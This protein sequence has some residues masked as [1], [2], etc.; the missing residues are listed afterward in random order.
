MY[1]NKMKRHDVYELIIVIAKEIAK[2]K[3]GA[4]FV[5][6]HQK[7]ARNLY[8]VLFPQ[9]HKRFY[10]SA[11]GSS[12]VIEQL[13]ML[14]GAVFI[15]DNG[16]LMAYG[17]KIMKSKPLYGHGTRHA[18]ALGITS[19]L[20]GSTAILVSEEDHFI[21]VFQHGKIILEMDAAEMPRALSDEIIS[22][23]ADGDTALL[24]AAGVSTAILGGAIIGPLAIIGGTYFA[25]KTASGVIKRRFRQ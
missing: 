2:K 24:T 17:A 1:N 4:L 5:I 9:I 16:M 22:F 12:K 13:A 18:A 25:I 11:E 23:I 6:A 20:K 14:D 19:Y 3:Q 7:K 21:K 8:K 10:I 15:S